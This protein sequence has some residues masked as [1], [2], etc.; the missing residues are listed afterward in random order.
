MPEEE[1]IKVTMAQALADAI[2]D[3]SM[4]SF[5]SFRCYV[6]GCVDEGD[7]S[8]SCNAVIRPSEDVPTQT[9]EEAVEVAQRQ[10]DSFDD[11]SELK[12]EFEESFVSQLKS[13]N[14]EGMIMGSDDQVQLINADAIEAHVEAEQPTSSVEDE[15]SADTS[16]TGMFV[17]IGVGVT[18][19]AVLAAALAFFILRRA[20]KA[21]GQDDD[22]DLGAGFEGSSL[23]SQD[24]HGSGLPPTNRLSVSELV[25]I[26]SSDADT[27]AVPM[28][29]ASST[30]PKAPPKPAP[31]RSMHHHH[32][33]RGSSLSTD[34]SSLSTDGSSL[35]T[36]GSSLS[37][38]QGSE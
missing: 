16:S 2:C 3:N 1:S 37:T 18:A 34:G 21:G 13:K 7:S 26:G 27:G 10:L 31:R 30:P 4:L 8:I 24:V 25:E 15:S 32:R 35:S 11:D 5:Y 6:T 17:G 14:L 38:T 33:R 28:A 19:V 20:H 23:A 29:I 9:T 36:D 22:D 12:K